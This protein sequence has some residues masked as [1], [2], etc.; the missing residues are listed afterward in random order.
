MRYFQGKVDDH[1]ARNAVRVV[2]DTL[3]VDANAETGEGGDDYY[4]CVRY[5]AASRPL[6]APAAAEK[7][8]SAWALKRSRLSSNGHTGTRLTDERNRPACSTMTRSLEIF[9]EVT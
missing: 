8:F 1:E 2:V 7:P 6:K 9:F 3:K 4:D 5:A